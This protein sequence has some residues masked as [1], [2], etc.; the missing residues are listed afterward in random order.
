MVKT[1]LCPSLQEQLY[2]L[3][4]GRREEAGPGQVDMS[5]VTEGLLSSLTGLMVSYLNSQ[6]TAVRQHLRVPVV[7]LRVRLT[8]S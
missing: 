3:A 5:E 8:L 2:H 1:M 6:L 7:T 4:E